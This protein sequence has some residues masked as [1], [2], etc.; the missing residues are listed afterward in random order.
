MKVLSRPIFLPFFLLSAGVAQAD[1]TADQVWQS[2]QDGAAAAGLTMA[3]DSM[4]RDG[5]VLRLSGVSV[6][7]ADGGQVNIA[8]IALT[9]AADGSVSVELPEAVAA[10]LSPA[11]G[12]AG[13]SLVQE[14]LTLTLREGDTPG[15]MSYDLR[16]NRLDGSFTS[17]DGDPAAGTETFSN[18]HAGLQGLALA[19]ATSPGDPARTTLRM[20]AAVLAY[21]VSMSSQPLDSSSVQSSTSDDVE[22]SLD[23]ALPAAMPLLAIAGLGDLAQALRDGMTARL[24]ISQGVTKQTDRT[25]DPYLD[26]DLAITSL[27]GTSVITLDRNGAALEGQVEGGALVGTFGDM[28]EGAVQAT[29]GAFDMLLRM[30]V[31]DNA[32]GDDFAL[33]LG[34]ADLSL[35]DGVWDM[36]DGARVFPRDP[37]SLRLDLAGKA[38]LDILGMVE[39]DMAGRAPDPARMPQILTLDLRELALSLAGARLTGQGAFAFATGADGVPVPDGRATLGL[40]GANALLDGAVAA[41]LA[42]ADDVGGLRMLMGMF[43]RP[44]DAPDS[45][46][47]EVEAR[48]DGSVLVNGMRLK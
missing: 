13:F 26:Y 14:G 15:A 47:S 5:A 1:L 23:L 2:W 43:L 9:E 7:R 36:F 31:L 3:A 46:T 35:A 22:I 37:A 33:R 25:T 17:G 44:G 45:L 41:G 10:V 8:R 42:T 30:P 16:A 28:P 21:E 40:T 24:A 34:L 27:P 12:K 11:S 38:R 39:D 4:A 19:G 20:T 29:F 48:P 32:G 18:F 6:A